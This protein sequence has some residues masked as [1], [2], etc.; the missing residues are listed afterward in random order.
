MID[1]R[2]L[3]LLREFDMRGSIAV[4]ITLLG[5]VGRNVQLG[6]AGVS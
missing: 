5:Q 1:V 3:V 2:C 6:I 4:G